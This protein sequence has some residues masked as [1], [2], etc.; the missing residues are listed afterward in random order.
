MYQIKKTSDILTKEFC[1][2]HRISHNAASKIAQE[3]LRMIATEVQ[4][5]NAVEIKGVC[6]MTNAFIT[7][8]ILKK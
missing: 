6:F 1:K 4:S 2:K 7:H 5:G 3:A 8:N